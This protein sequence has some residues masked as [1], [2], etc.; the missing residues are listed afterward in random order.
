MYFSINLRQ[1]INR[2]IFFTLTNYNSN[3]FND[4]PNHACQ[5]T[6][7][8]NLYQRNTFNLKKV[9]ISNFKKVKTGKYIFLKICKD[10]YIDKSPKRMLIMSTQITVYIIFI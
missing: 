6:Q 10:I 7:I 9:K 5:K 3:G 4:M 1:L 8:G 2:Q